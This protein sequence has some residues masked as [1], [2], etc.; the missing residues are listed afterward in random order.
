MLSGCYYYGDPYYRHH[1]YYGGGYGGYGGDVYYD[2]YYGPYEG[3]YWGSDGYFYYNDR[4]HRSRRDDERHY[5]H[6]HW[7]DSE[8]YQSD[9]HDQDRDGDG[10][11]DRDHDRY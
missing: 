1:G 2:G 3:G 9:R 11:G 6:E 10:D 8:R 4:D 7:G 5:R